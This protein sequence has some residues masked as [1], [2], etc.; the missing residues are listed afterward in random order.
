M[1]KALVHEVR[2]I[3]I[4]K[5]DCKGCE[6][7]AFPKVL[8]LISRGLIDVDQIQLEVHGNSFSQA[9]VLFSAAN[10]TQMRVFHKEMNH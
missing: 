5:V 4:L 2:R 8:S 7:S 6:W 9:G 10:E 1:F 3:N